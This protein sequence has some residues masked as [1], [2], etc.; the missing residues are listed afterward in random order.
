[1]KP[2]MPD[3]EAERLAALRDYHILDTQPEQVFD[4]VTRL[5]SYICKVP[6]ATIS[7]V[8]ES[9]QWF[10]SKLGLDP[11]ETP[12]EVAFCAYAVLQQAPLIVRDALKDERFAESELVRKAPRIRFYAVSR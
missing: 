8:D 7:L 2:P 11:R 9:R 12:R 6:I 5:A 3:C 10:K 1:M 4:D